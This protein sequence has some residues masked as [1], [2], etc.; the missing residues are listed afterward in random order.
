MYAYCNN[1]PVMYVDPTGEVALA[2]ALGGAA[3]WKIGLAAVSVIAVAY[4][5]DTLVHNPSN[6]PSIP[7]LR[8]RSRL[9]LIPKI[10]EREKE[11]TLP[12]PETIIYSYG[13][14]FYPTSKDMYTFRKGEIP[15]VSFALTPPSNP[16]TLY[17]I[18][19]IEELNK[20]GIFT[21]VI[22]GPNHVSVRPTGLLGSMEMWYR[23]GENH[24][25]TY[26]LKNM[27]KKIR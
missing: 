1:N 27:T 3:L 5:A 6:L 20:S 12:P 16:D 8:E 24:P 14:V 21:A 7:T 4:A 2:F 23:D 15:A 13:D 10:K 22:D 9:N 18:T 11:A 17:S 19:T 25:Y 26:A